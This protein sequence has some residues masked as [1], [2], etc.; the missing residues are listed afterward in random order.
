MI[1]ASYVLAAIAGMAAVTVL[2]R[3][4]PFLAAPWLKRFAL[5]DRLGRYLPPAIMTLLVLHS[6]RGSAA[7]NPAGV[8]Q[9]LTAIGVAIALQLWLRQALASIL[10]ATVLYVAFRN[11]PLFG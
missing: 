5:V 2:L 11:L 4:V 8:W 1:R 9:E 10:A 3:A 6:L 7:E